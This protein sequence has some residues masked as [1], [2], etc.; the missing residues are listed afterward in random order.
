MNVCRKQPSA[1]WTLS[2]YY[3]RYRLLLLLLSLKCGLILVK[4]FIA[5]PFSA[6]F[7]HIC[8]PNIQ[9]R[10]RE[11]K[12][13]SSSEMKEDLKFFRGHFKTLSSM[14]QICKKFAEDDFI[15]QPKTFYNPPPA[16]QQ[17]QPQLHVWLGD[18]MNLKVRYDT[19]IW[20][21]HTHRLTVQPPSTVQA[22]RTTMSQRL[23][24]NFLPGR[25]S[26][27]SDVILLWYWHQGT[28]GISF[29]LAG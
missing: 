25:T 21:N 6:V 8:R 20:I 7:P 19:E 5:E 16:Q 12:K 22:K 29:P 24:D 4:R 11:S 3:N 1:S 2:W 27:C 14:I 26:A 28:W 13:P 18:I 17:Q 15:W 10:S 9:N 23:Y